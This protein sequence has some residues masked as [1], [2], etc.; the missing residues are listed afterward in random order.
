MDILLDNLFENEETMAVYKRHPE[1]VK[2]S[3]YIVSVLQDRMVM[4][5]YE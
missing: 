3:D 5:Y 1:H 2:A 4:D